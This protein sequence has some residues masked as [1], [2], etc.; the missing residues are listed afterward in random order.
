MNP[1]AADSHNLRPAD[2]YAW[3]DPRILSGALDEEHGGT[4]CEDWRHPMP[5]TV[6]TY[7][8]CQNSQFC[9]GFTIMLQRGADRAERRVGARSS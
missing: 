8:T 2:T 6:S 4:G 3:R 1:R 7:P 9:V 5:T